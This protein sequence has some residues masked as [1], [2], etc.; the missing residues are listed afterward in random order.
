[1]NRTGSL[2][3]ALSMVAC[4]SV[5]AQQKAKSA[6]GTK[7]PE[8]KAVPRRVLEPQVYLGNSANWGG[9]IQKNTFRELM[10]QGLTSK[11]SMGRQY[12]IISFNF[13]Y[14]ERNLYEDSVG[15]LVVK[16]DFSTTYCHGDT[17]PDVL[18]RYIPASQSK[19]GEESPG[20]YQRVKAGDTVYFDRISVLRYTPNTP[21]P[22]DSLAIM[23]KGMKFTIV[24]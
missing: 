11:D 17:L 23:G 20:I 3:V 9:T 18:T 2:I 8:Q 22:A 13:T 16:A 7:Q 21:L 24:K 1:M 14:A 19:I 12:K 15:N 6:A 5:F 10:K 4:V